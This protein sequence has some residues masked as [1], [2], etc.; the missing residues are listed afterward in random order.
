MDELTKF[1]YYG[2]WLVC[3]L[4]TAALVV[5]DG[6]LHQDDDDFEFLEAVAAKL[7]ADS[8]DHMECQDWIDLLTEVGGGALK[9]DEEVAFSYVMSFRDALT[10]LLSEDLQVK[11]PGG[12]WVAV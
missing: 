4:Q 8:D 10:C 9:V 3:Q 11:Y 7:R 12:S 1:E 5:P 2:A 6:Q